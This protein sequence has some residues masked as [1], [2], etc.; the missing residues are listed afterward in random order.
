MFS[1]SYYLFRCVK[2]LKRFQQT[3]W[4]QFSWINPVLSP[5]SPCLAPL[6][7]LHALWPGL[8]PAVQTKP[9]LL[10]HCPPSLQI[11]VLC[12]RLALRDNGS[13]GGQGLTRV[14]ILSMALYSS[15]ILFFSSAPSCSD[16]AAHLD[17]IAH[18][19]LFPVIPDREREQGKPWYIWMGW[20]ED[21][22]HKW[23]SNAAE[24]PIA[25][26]NL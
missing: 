21:R 25:V 23:R 11:P 12:W 6:S 8:R 10:A 1:V 24:Q 7:P 3:S 22:T 15:H 20:D 17:C 16:K 4:L 13:W 2:K 5:P 19:S 26:K 9:W 14:C 18:S